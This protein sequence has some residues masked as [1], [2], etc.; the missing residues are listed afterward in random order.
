MIVLKHDT[1]YIKF[2]F[3]KFSIIYSDKT[4]LILTN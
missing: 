2:I 3:Y 4:K 1:S